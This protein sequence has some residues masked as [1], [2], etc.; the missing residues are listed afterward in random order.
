MLT[1]NQAWTRCIAMWEYVA[2]EVQKLIDIGRWPEQDN[3]RL[4]IINRLKTKWLDFNC[5]NIPIDGS[6]WLCEYCKSDCRNCPANL[7]LK[8]NIYC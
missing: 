4:D 2:D 1:L 6:C 3:F 8:Q 7:A 5:Y